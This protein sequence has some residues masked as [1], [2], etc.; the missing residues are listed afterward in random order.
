L[1]R[2]RSTVLRFAIGGGA[3]ALG[4]VAAFQQAPPGGY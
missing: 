3:L 4:I 2:D 1:A